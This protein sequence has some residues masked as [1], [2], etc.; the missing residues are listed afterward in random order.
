[1]AALTKSRPT[2]QRANTAQLNF[3]MIAGVQAFAGGLAML[4]SGHLRPAREGQGADNAAKAADAALC[5]V[6]GL[7][8][9]DVKGG[10]ANGDVRADLRAGCFPFAN[11]AAGDAITEAEVGR[12]CYV[13]DD[14][15][16]AKTN[17]NAT[18]PVAGCVIEVRDGLVWV[19]I[20]PAISAALTA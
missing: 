5:R 1:M 12:A 2:P 13:I 6:V 11:S 20:H 16:V 15:T 7:F 10:A 14:Q 3:G 17:P 8:E 9:A 18:R 19:E 4:A